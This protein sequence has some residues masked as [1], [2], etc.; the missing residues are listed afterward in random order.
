MAMTKAEKA[1]FEELG[2]LS[3]LRWTAPVAHDVPAPSA[4]SGVT[5]EG[6]SFNVHTMDVDLWWSSSGTHCRVPKGFSA[7]Q[8]GVR[9]FSTRLLALKACRH[10]MEQEFAKKLREMDKRI[11]EELAASTES[12]NHRERKG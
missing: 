10:A 3:A 2:V 5:T 4:G 11:E 8:G 12:A 9:L 6:W 7:T 1:A